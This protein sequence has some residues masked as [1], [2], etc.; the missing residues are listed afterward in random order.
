MSERRFQLLYLRGGRWR[1]IRDYSAASLKEALA[2]FAENCPLVMR[3]KW[4]VAEYRE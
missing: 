3:G 4:A 1:I 2:L